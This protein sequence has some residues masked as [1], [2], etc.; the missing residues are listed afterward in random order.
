MSNN[1]LQNLDFLSSVL[2]D[3]IVFT[4]FHILIGKPPEGGSKINRLSLNRC[5]HTR[6]SLVKG[7]RFIRYVW[8]A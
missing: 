4:D 6:K 1:L 5:R 2:I 8:R 3:R 7:E